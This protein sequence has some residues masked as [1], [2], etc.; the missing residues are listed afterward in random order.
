MLHEAPLVQL[1]LLTLL[2]AFHD[3]FVLTSR[4]RGLR[5]AV[6]YGFEERFTLEMHRRLARAIGAASGRGGP[7]Q[8]A[9]GTRAFAGRWRLGCA[10]SAAG[11][12]GALERDIL[13]LEDP[14]KLAA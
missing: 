8:D 10:T 9:G 5:R 11:T 14:M 4:R 2:Y 13:W 12:E 1:P 7:L 3:L 6:P